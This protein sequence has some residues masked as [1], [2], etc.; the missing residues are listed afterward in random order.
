MIVRVTDRPTVSLPRRA[1]RQTMRIQRRALSALPPDL[2]S[3]LP[4]PKSEPFNGQEG[5][6]AIAVEIARKCRIDRVIETGTFRGAT[7]GLLLGIF[8]VPVATVE[9]DPRF[10]ARVKRNLGHLPKIELNLGDSRSL[11]RDLAARPDWNQ[12][13]VFVYLDA[14][15]EHDLPLAEELQIIAAT[16]PEAVVMIDDFEVPDDPGYGFDDYGS[17]VGALTA[18]ILPPEVAGWRLLYPAVRSSDETGRRRGSCVLVS[19]A[20]GAIEFE[21]LRA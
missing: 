11:L 21:T 6:T 14:H 4:A 13:R 2:A 9:A 17:E 15:W 16:W 8:G 18:A 10:Y 12:H 5:R 20:L 7:T 1:W 3:R 19:P